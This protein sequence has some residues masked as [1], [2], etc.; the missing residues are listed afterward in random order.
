MFQ[1]HLVPSWASPGVGLFLKVAH[2]GLFVFSG[3][4]YL[5]TKIWGLECSVLLEK[6]H[7][8]N[9]WHQDAFYRLR[10]LTISLLGIWLFLFCHSS[11][12]SQ[13][14]AQQWAHSQDPFPTLHALLSAG[15]TQLSC[16]VSPFH[17]GSTWEP[18][19]YHLQG[20]TP[21]KLPEGKVYFSWILPYTDLWR[22][23]FCSKL[24][25]R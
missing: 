23:S 9:L 14:W 25:S 7:V 20:F 5:E 2:F 19:C 15:S 21:G 17:G 16:P 24:D 13:S 3:E 12:S 11:V 10:C 1:G 8:L 4:W 6:M 22:S 18:V